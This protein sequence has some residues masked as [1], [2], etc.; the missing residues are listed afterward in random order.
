MRV[1]YLRQ[2]DTAQT[3]SVRCLGYSHSFRH[4]FPQHFAR[5]WG[6]MHSAHVGS[7]VVIEIIH[8]FNVFSL[9]SENDVPISI[10]RDRPEAGLIPGEW[11]QPPARHIQ[12]LR[13]GGIV[14]GAKLQLQFSGVVGLDA[15]LAAFSEE[16]FQSLVPERSIENRIN[17]CQRDDM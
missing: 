9:E 17:N 7:S 4:P 5:V 15:G 10:H 2:R 13:Q 12:V 14:Q 3:E 8:Q 6:V 11:M 1:E 16:C